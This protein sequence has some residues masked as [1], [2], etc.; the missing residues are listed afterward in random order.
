MLLLY[1]FFSGFLKIKIMGDFPERLINKCVKNNIVLW[2][3]KYLK[4]AIVFKVSIKDFKKIFRIR[5]GLKIKIEILKKYGFPFIIRRYKNR[6]GIIV[7]VIIFILFIYFMS[8]FVWNIEINGN[9]TVSET[10]I[11]RECESLGIKIGVKKSKLN[12]KILADKFR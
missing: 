1:R 5:K 3:I 6:Y 11:L 9:K 12:T 2:N 7:G 4:N 8:G 10:Q